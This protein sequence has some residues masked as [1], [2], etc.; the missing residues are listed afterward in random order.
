MSD[1]DLVDESAEAAQSVEVADGSP[2][3]WGDDFDAARA[4]QTISHLRGRE[5]ELES[6]AK[7]WKRFREDED[8]RR[9]TLTELGYS[10]ADDD[11]EDLDDEDFD[12]E[13]VTQVPKALQKELDELKTWRSQQEQKEARQAFDDHLNSLAQGAEIE[14]SPFERRAILAAS[15]EAGFKPQHTEKAF[16]E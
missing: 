11:D 1:P 9:E 15:I 7:A 13:P 16:K 2:P 14:L 3:P 10:I 12:D 8:A 6:D 4:W 5:K